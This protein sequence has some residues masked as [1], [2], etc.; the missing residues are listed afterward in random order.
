MRCTELRFTAQH[1]RSQH[2]FGRGEF[3]L[4]D[5]QPNQSLQRVSDKFIVQTIRDLDFAKVNPVAGP[6]YVDG[7]DHITLLYDS[8]YAQQY[9]DALKE[10]LS[11]HAT[12]KAESKKTARATALSSV[13]SSAGAPPAALPGP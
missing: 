9:I 4:F 6:V 10:F 5:Q 11:E 2:V 8:D 13:P 12:A 3:V 7:A 1:I